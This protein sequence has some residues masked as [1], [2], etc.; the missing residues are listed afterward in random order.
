MDEF[1]FVT[2]IMLMVITG[3]FQQVTEVEAVSSYNTLPLYWAWFLQQDDSSIFLNMSHKLLNDSLLEVPEF[4]SDVKEF[5]N[6]TTTE[7]I[8]GYYSQSDPYSHG[9]HCTAMFNGFYPNYTDGAEEYAARPEVEESVGKSF[10]LKSIG[11]ILTPRTFGARL[12]LTEEQLILW[13]NKEE[14]VKNLP[15]VNTKCPTVV[16]QGNRIE[17]IPQDA[18]ILGNFRPTSGIGSRAHLTL[19]CAPGISAV[20]TGLDLI[21]IIHQESIADE[22]IITYNLTNGWL[23]SYG[24]G[25]WVFYPRTQCLLPSQFLGYTGV[26]AASAT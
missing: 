20:T 13:N 25:R 18:D 10:T 23:R 17:I 3:R 9:L 15:Q 26:I 24:L 22:S 1:W 7:E 11:W 12:H 19:G 14:E 6:Q 5:T 4:F 2:T 8:I 21:D 16:Y